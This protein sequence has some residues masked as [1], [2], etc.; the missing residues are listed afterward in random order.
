MAEPIGDESIYLRIAH[1]TSFHVR[2]NCAAT[3]PLVRN[4][5]KE[6]LAI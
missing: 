3:N 5:A 2:L 1:E 6:Q 4:R